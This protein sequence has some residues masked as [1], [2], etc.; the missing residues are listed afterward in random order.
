MTSTADVFFKATLVGIGG[1]IVLD[2]YALMMSRVLGASA[3]NWAMVGRWFGNM[4]HGQFVQIAMSEAAPSKGELAIGWIAHYAIGI[5][6][7]LLLSALWG[8]V[9]LDRPTLL[10][11]LILAWVLLAAPYLIMMPGMGMGI[12][13]SRTS[14]PNITRLKSVMGHSVFGIGMYATGRLLALYWP[15]L[16]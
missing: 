1:T 14:K 12:A 4:A 13:G 16:A 2:L 11:P 9:W 10:P 6:Y 5:C 8:K 15:T 7:G 3:T